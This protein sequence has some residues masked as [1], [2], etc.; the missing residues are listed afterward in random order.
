MFFYHKK[1]EKKVKFN[2]FSFI[3]GLLWKELRLKIITKKNYEYVPGLIKKKIKFHVCPVVQ[4]V[5]NS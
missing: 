1:K 4:K 2:E 3:T 5:K